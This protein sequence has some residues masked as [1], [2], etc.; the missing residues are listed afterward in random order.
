M[1]AYFSIQEKLL[2]INDNDG[3]Q[4]KEFL[5]EKM[6]DFVREHCKIDKTLFVPIK[7]LNH[8]WIQYS[9]HHEFNEILREYCDS[10]YYIINGAIFFDNNLIVDNNMYYGIGLMSWPNTSDDYKKY[11]E[12][13]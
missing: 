7:L 4:M 12:S 11:W 8:A 2:S 1:G 13:D 10:K 3:L 9:C 5:D 6:N